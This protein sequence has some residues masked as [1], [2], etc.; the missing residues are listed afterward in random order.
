M[1]RIFLS[2][3]L[4]CLIFSGVSA[5]TLIDQIERAYCTLDSASYIDDVISSYARWRDKL[6]NETYKLYMELLSSNEADSLYS[7][8]SKDKKILD[9]KAIKEF[10]DEVKSGTPVYVLNL[11]RKDEKTLQ[12]DTTK[13]CFNLFYFGKRCKGR[14]YVYCDG[15][16]YVSQDEYFCTF[17]RKHGKNAPK[18]FR[19]IMRKHPKY[20]LFCPDLEGM[21]TILYVIDNE[22]YIY[23]IVEM[24]EYKLDDY[25]KAAGEF[26]HTEFTP[27]S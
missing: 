13:L 21:N 16:E 27:T 14:L 19:K 20:L 9:A 24:Q 1:K 25:M 2:C 7:E 15:G 23:R 3:I 17:S 11:K 8:Y 10:E 18:V 22:V 4:S 26:A 12:A 6:S 5:Q